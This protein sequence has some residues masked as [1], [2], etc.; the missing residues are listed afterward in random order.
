MRRIDTTVTAEGPMRVSSFFPQ[1]E[2]PWPAIIMVCDGFGPR[3]AMDELAI[4]QAEAGFVVAVYD[5]FH[6]AGSILDLVP[7]A[8]EIGPLI[9]RVLGEPSLREPWRQRFYAAATK[10]ENIREDIGAVLDL[11]EATPEVRRAPV[12]LMGYCMGGAISM[13]AAA[14]FPERIGA[15]AAFHPGG[16]VTDAENSPHRGISQM[17]AAVLIGAAKD[18]P[19]FPP[20]A[21]GQLDA[22]LEAAGLAHQIEFYPALHGF[23]VPD[24]PTY[25][26]PCRARHH[27]EA[28]KFFRG[29]LPS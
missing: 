5:V 16:L 20:S 2:G 29:H 18:D 4:A 21:K 26:A 25:D 11:L 6:R 19:S 10:P 24:T 23:C 14:A 9:P 27:E 8:T 22:D 15:I 13:R 17:R 7:G 1:G 12:A 28:T 3:P